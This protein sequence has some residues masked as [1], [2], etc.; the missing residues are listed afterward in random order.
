LILVPEAGR[1]GGEIV[2]KGSQEKIINS[3]ES[4]TGRYSFRKT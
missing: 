3:K 1:H 2:F 4:L